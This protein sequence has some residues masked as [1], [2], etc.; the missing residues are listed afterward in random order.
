MV[1]GESGPPARPRAPPPPPLSFRSLATPML[2]PPSPSSPAS[3]RRLL[4]PTSVAAA[5]GAPSIWATGADGAGVRVGVFDTGVA[6]GHPH[7][8]H[9]DERSNWTHEPTLD[10][11]LG[12]GSFVAGVV[13]GG[14]A[15]CPGLAPGVDL[16]T[17]RVFTNDQVSFTS[18][19]LDAFNY[20]MESRVHVVNLSIGGPDWLDAPFVDKVMIG[21][22]SERGFNP[23][24]VLAQSSPQPRFVPRPCI[25][26]LDLLHPLGAGSD[27]GRHR[28]GLRH[29]QR[30]PQCRHPQQ[31]CRHAG[32]RGGRRHRV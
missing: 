27:V 19:F 8:A 15:E 4:A 12:H 10:D 30:R 22:E 29:R 28:H 11:G 14:G 26:T 13:A 32:R 2:L 18:W 7:I 5:V 16:L 3:S 1:E 17:F 6:A 23:A 25:H 24:L 9:I 20:A 31:P 21:R